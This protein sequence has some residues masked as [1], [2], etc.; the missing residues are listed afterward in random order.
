[1]SASESLHHAD[2]IKC[3]VLFIL[4]T[5]TNPRSSNHPERRN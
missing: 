2:S 1:M 4:Y 5:D 3:K